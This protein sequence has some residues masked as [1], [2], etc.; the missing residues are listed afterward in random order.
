MSRGSTP[1]SSTKQISF[2]LDNEQKRNL[3]FLKNF[4][5]I[6]IQN[7]RRI[8]QSL[9]K[10]YYSKCFVFILDFGFKIASCYVP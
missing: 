7:E 9:C 8:Q 10:V 5:I 3:I 6:F 4:Y 1:T 2:D